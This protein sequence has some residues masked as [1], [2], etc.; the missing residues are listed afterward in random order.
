MRLVFALCMLC[1]I[2]SAAV[3]RAQ[4][5]AS[6]DPLRLPTPGS[7]ASM[8]VNIHFTDPANGELE[9]LAAAGF[10]WIRMD[11]AWG[12][13]EH[14]KGNYDFSAYDR[15][16]AQLTRF[17]IRAIYILDYGNDLYEKGAP[18]S[19]EARTAFAKF[20]AAAVVHFK[21]HG[22]L[23]EMW[24]EPNGGFW[25]PN[26]N[27]DEY[28]AL[29]LDT[30]KAIKAA[31]PQELY[32]GPATSGMDFNFIEPC[33]KAGLLKYWDAVSFHP[34][35]DSAPE[36]A[37]PD[38][39]RVKSMIKQ[40]APAGKKIPIL[41]G[42][43]GYSELYGGLNLDLQSRYIVRE[44]LT[45]IFNDLIVSIWYD[46]H[47]DGP[48]PKETEHHFGTVF[49][50]YQPKPTYL[51]AKTLSAQLGGFTFNKR[52]MLNDISDYCLLFTDKTGHVCLAAW[53]VSRIA[54][55]VVIPASAGRFHAV[56]FTGSVEEV[57]SDGNGVKI[58]IEN[59]PVYLKPEGDNSQLKVAAAWSA[60]PQTATAGSESD[61]KK[62][63]AAALRLPENSNVSNISVLNLNSGA[64]VTLQ[65]QGGDPGSAASLS[66]VIGVGQGCTL[67]ITLETSHHAK[68]RQQIYLQPIHPLNFSAAPTREGITPVYIVNRT[69]AAFKGRISLV[70]EPQS[71]TEM[72]FRR[73][74]TSKI[75]AV[76]SKEQT[77]TNYSVQLLFEELDAS[78]KWRT[79]LK[80]PV[81]K[82][83]PFASFQDDSTPSVR[84]DEFT[85]V[86]DG[87]PKIGSKLTM[88]VVPAP[89]GLPGHN[90]R[91]LNIHYEFE[92]GW[93]FLK[94]LPQGKYR[95]PL[96]GTPWHLGMWVYGDNS[97]N[98]LNMRYSDSAGKTFQTS[99]GAI[100]WTGW[101]FVQ[102]S[103]DP[104][105]ASHWGGDDTSNAQYPITFDTV[106]LV[107]SANRK[108]GKGEIWVA[109]L[110]LIQ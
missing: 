31:A 69:G 101:R 48:D 35:R 79:S 42:E 60:V 18:R 64:S 62:I 19:P 39:D 30:G 100:T 22:I 105:E 9:Q 84:S 47:D 13:I 83:T 72:V 25:L 5:R 92:P 11:F 53:T 41:S 81:L 29:A 95:T 87:D 68:Y 20:A 109:D 56:N 86:P 44:F 2:G 80:T 15:L 24:N 55:D 90:R 98:I 12:G 6:S 70:G 57:A 102:F 17:G 46:W 16:T 65:R 94:L 61:V 99:A 33:F 40:Y 21:G 93:K 51:A 63:I 89:E 38:F 73:G 37:I 75:V 110:T 23:W 28:I 74:E 52:L 8:G 34:Y 66:P 1:S 59:A 71:T 58:R 76:K 36:T 106:V 49:Q 26:A 14:T 96:T 4:I 97:G 27:V 85:L 78:G 104:R 107:D 32:I 82:Y 77:D 3:A 10:K 88:E 103:L 43:W 45:D 7:V 91:A 67:E 50:D 108:G 54:H